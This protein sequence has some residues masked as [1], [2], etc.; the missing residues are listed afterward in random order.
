MFFAGIVVFLLAIFYPLF[1]F[2]INEEY[3]GNL[4]INL[5][6]MVIV[7]AYVLHYIA[8]V[9]SENEIFEYDSM[10]STLNLSDRYAITSDPFTRFNLTEREIEIAK[11]IIE[12]FSYIQIAERTFI[13]TGTVRKHASTIFNKVGV[14]NLKEFIKE[15]SSTKFN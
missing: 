11:M 8:Q 13:S 6:F 15:F 14:N 7:L 3:F 9:K 5:V 12:G 10:F 4:F 1:Q 2:G